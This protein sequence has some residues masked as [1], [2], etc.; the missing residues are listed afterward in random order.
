[1]QGFGG[2]VRAI[3]NVDLST[4]A[5]AEFS[6][7]LDAQRIDLAETA[8]WLAPA[9]QR[10]VSGTMDLNMSIDGNGNRWERIRTTLDGDGSFRL[11]RG[12]LENVN[13]ADEVLRSLTGI[14]GLSG[15]LSPEFRKRHPALFT[16]GSTQFDD[17]TSA[18]SMKDGRIHTDNLALK[19]ADYSMAASGT[20][21]LDRTADLSARFI[22]SK[23]LSQDL[24]GEVSALRYLTD[25]GGNV[26][27]PFR[28]AGDLTSAHPQ[29]DKQFVAQALQKAL[30]GNLTDQL[31]RPRN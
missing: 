5:D 30:I 23:K 10:L 21:G 9:A 19:A 24:I 28:L 15:L 25:S 3:G 16:T 18:I 20:V 4:A 7:K 22:A 11:T 1:M 13:L 2:E 17:L 14:P 31:F 29:L 6:L 27:I 12:R 26:A 8:A